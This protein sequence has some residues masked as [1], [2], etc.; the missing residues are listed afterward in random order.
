MIWTYSLS[1][2]LAGYQSDHIRL[3][4]DKTTTVPN[5]SP[6]ACNVMPWHDGSSWPC[7]SYG[8][9]AID[10]LQQSTDYCRS[11][12]DKKKKTIEYDFLIVLY[13]IIILLHDKLFR[14]YTIVMMIYLMNKYISAYYTLHYII[15]TYP[16]EY[17]IE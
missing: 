15:T 4:S 6:T 13:K 12:S 8:I 3:A 17:K 10:I 1:I 2:I 16:T 5:V 9:I 14:E 11:S 7:N